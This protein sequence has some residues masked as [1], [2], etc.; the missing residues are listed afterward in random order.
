MLHYK[1][2]C[3]TIWRCSQYFKHSKKKQNRCTSK[4]VTTGG[5]VYVKGDHNHVSTYEEQYY[6]KSKSKVITIIR[7]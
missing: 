6:K 1:L 5:I 7:Q 4:L 3:K 2:P